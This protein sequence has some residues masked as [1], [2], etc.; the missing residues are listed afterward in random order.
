[1]EIN[2]SKINFAGSGGGGICPP[3]PE[4]KS[5][6]KSVEI[7]ENGSS[8]VTPDAEYDGLSEVSI[9]VAVPIPTYTSQSK[10]YN[11]TSNGNTTITVD[12]GYDG[13]TGGTISVAVPIPQLQSKDY[14]IVTNGDTV[15]SPDSGFGGISGGTISVNVPTPSPTLQEK[16]VSITQNGQSSVTADTGYDGLSKVDISVNVANPAT[17]YDISLPYV[18]LSYSLLN[19][20]MLNNII[21]WDKLTDYV[22]PKVA[23]STSSYETWSIDMPNLTNK[24]LPTKWGAGFFEGSIGIMT[25]EGNLDKL[26]QGYRFFADSS[27]TNFNSNLPSLVNGNYMFYNC[28]NLSSWN[29]DL[30]NLTDG[31]YMFYKTSLS[32]WNIE[33]PKLTNGDTMFYNC[34]NLTTFT[35]NLSSL[36]NGKYMFNYCGLTSWN[37]ELPNLTN[38]DSMFY[39]TSLSSWNIELPKLTNGTYMFAFNQQLTTFISNLSSLTSASNMFNGCDIL[40]NITLTGTL[41]CNNFNLSK[42]TNLTVDSLMSV[43][44][45]LVD[46]TGQ[47]SKTLKLGS[48]N[49]NKLSE[50]QKAIATNKNW[51]LQ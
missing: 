1:M 12:E 36:T 22:P 37:I 30:P 42:C 48:T 24:T 7:T 28:L 21:G 32:S 14:S 47:T 27:F 40:E 16:S 31:T 8:S 11:I 13:I 51:I 4:Y 43:I 5:Q 45:A 50:E 15:I 29:I 46:L 17:T 23:F 10:N 33:L 25:Y 44:N 20:E 6:E 3:C 19:E 39:K 2:I 41:N 9:N 38:G 34:R 26:E 18:N 35:S 49:L